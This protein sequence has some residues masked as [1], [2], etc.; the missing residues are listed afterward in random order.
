[1]GLRGLLVVG[2]VFLG[3]CCFM[4][5]FYCLCLVVL[6]LISCC[7]WFVAWLTFWVGCVLVVACSMT[8]YSLV[9]VY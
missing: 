2:F 8:G 5:N 9:F 7:L 1:M 6:P 3:L 4:V